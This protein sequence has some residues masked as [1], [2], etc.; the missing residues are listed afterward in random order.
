MPYK[1]IVRHDAGASHW[2]LEMVDNNH[3]H[4]PV[5]A[6]S[7]L[8]QHRIAAMTPQERT[9]VRDMHQLGHSPSQILKYNF[10]GFAVLS[11][12]SRAIFN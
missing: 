11:H 4:G 5:A 7:A 10:N 8:P 9:V 1:V 3:N 12:C 6:L 2:K